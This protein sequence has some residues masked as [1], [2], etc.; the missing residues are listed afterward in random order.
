MPLTPI[1]SAASLR[2]L[3]TTSGLD[4][5]SISSRSERSDVEIELLQE[6]NQAFHRPASLARIFHGERR[7]H[8]GGRGKRTA[9][10]P[11]RKCGGSVP[12]ESQLELAHAVNLERSPNVRDY[13]TQAIRIELPGKQFAYPDFLVRTTSGE[14]EVHEVNPSIKHLTKES[15]DRFRFMRTTLAGI[16]IGFR[17]FDF[18]DLPSG[19]SLNALLRC[20]SRAHI[21][22]H[23]RAEIDLAKYLLVNSGIESLSGAYV[24]LQEHELSPYLADYLAFHQQWTHNL[25]RHQSPNGGV[26]G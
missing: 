1:G 8:Q 3:V 5:S 4:R 18:N 26:D 20:Y 9:L 21:K 7:I 24:L 12:L 22:L 16:G 13:R 17:L 2:P 14:I 6:I 25:D 10:F 11:S 19:V 15:N 23:A